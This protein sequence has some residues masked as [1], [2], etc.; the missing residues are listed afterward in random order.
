MATK[1]FSFWQLA[2]LLVEG[3]GMMHGGV[4]CGRDC[5]GDGYRR[6]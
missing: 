3:V 2:N 5:H 6:W 1:Q 4:L